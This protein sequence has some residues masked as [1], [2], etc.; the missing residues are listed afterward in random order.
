MVRCEVCDNQYFP[1]HPDSFVCPECIDFHVDMVGEDEVER[2]EFDNM[3]G[4]MDEYDL[5][6]YGHDEY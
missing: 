6:Y 4:Y 1:E 2:Q 5:G 3:D